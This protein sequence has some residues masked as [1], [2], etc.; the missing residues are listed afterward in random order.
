[1]ELI[2]EENMGDVKTRERRQRDTIPIVFF[3][4]F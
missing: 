4:L 3:S 2:I 1:M